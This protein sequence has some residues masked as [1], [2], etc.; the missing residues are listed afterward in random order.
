MTVEEL[1][2]SLGLDR[3]RPTAVIFTHVGWGRDVFLRRQPVC[4]L[5]RMAGRDGAGGGRRARRELDRQGPPRQPLE[6]KGEPAKRGPR[7]GPPPRR[8]GA[9]ADSRERSVARTDS[10]VR[11]DSLF[12][13]TDVA[14]QCG[15]RSVSDGVHGKAS[16]HG[17]HRTL[18]RIGFTIDPPTRADYLATLGRINAI[19]APTADQTDRAARYV[20]ALIRLRTRD[21]ELGRSPAAGRSRRHGSSGRRPG[22]SILQHRGLRA[23]PDLN[24]LVTWIW[25]ARR[26]T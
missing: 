2:Q 6:G 24:R 5:R 22:I 21:G 20:D 9:G 26:R 7:S 23:A 12:D 1:R 4:R 18:L 3:A 25:T 13:L 19:S 8:R 15:A 16:G 11:T 10:P 17:W 14:S